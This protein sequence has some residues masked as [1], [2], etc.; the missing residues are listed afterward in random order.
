MLKNKILSISFIVLCAFLLETKVVLAQAVVDHAVVNAALDAQ[1]KSAP[2]AEAPI[3][4][5]APAL[6]VVKAID[7]Q[8]NK[9]IGIAQILSKIK[10]RVGEDYQE[11]VVSDDLKRL[12]NTG[13]FADV[14]IDHEDLDGGFTGLL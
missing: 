12:Y 14:Q 11:A 2:K 3:P 7:I 13:H 4:E 8:G 6:K 1:D 10:T 9:S 5:A